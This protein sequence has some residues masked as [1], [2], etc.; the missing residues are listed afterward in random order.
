MVQHIKQKKHHCIKTRQLKTPVFQDLLLNGNAL[1][2][3]SVVLRKEL[4]QK[5]GDISED[6]EL[7]TIEDYDVWLKIARLTDKFKLIPKTL[8]YYWVGGGN[9]SNYQRTIRYLNV[10]E[11]LYA[12]EIHQL[13]GNKGLW[14]INYTRSKIF[15]QTRDYKKALFSINK[16]SLRHIMRQIL[17]W[18]QLVSI[19]DPRH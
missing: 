14:W 4:L 1:A 5:S 13:S 10:F 16:L 9:T 6:K 2:N 3:S 8:G 17:S 11:E 18:L 19:N 7:V 12:D 15:I